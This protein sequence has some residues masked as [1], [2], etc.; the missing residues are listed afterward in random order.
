[1]PFSP[2]PF[3]RRRSDSPCH[4]NT[5]SIIFPFLTEWRDKGK[6]RHS[7]SRVNPLAAGRVALLEAHLNPIGFHGNQNGFS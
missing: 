1:M 2:R 4:K 6:E 3:L 7:P 5:Q